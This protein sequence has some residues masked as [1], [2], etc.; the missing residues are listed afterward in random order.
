MVAAL[1]G[2]G[3]SMSNWGRFVYMILRL[4]SCLNLSD[5]NVATGRSDARHANGGKVAL[6]LAISNF[7]SHNPEAIA[8]GQRK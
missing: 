4:R 6:M 1:P 3:V 5:V 8:E 7:S 2:L